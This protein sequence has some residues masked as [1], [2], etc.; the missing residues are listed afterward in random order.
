MCGQW[1]VLLSL[2]I[3]YCINEFSKLRL[4]VQAMQLMQEKL[5]ERVGFEQ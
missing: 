2:F 3:I 1:I 4:T 5:M